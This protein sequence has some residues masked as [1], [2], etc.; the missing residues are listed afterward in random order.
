VEL[1]IN[2]ASAQDYTHSRTEPGYNLPIVVPIDDDGPTLGD[3]F[4]DICPAATEV[5]EERYAKPLVGAPDAALG[6]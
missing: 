4:A 1:R 3:R 2:R 6:R 5:A